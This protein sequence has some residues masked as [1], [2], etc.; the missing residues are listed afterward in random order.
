VAGCALILVSELGG[1]DWLRI[2]GIIFISFG[3]TFLGILAGLRPPM[4]RR[5]QASLRPWRLPA[6][7]V[8]TVLFCLPVLIGLIGGL[9]GLAS[10]FNQHN[11]TA[12]V[13]GGVAI[14]LLMIVA[15]VASALA[16]ARSLQRASHTAEPGFGA[17]GHNG[18]R[19]GDLT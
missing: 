10:A 7:L 12:V 6:S 19:D 2:I 13:A 3:A 14:D 5:W 11:H 17:N 8:L 18:H 1:I 4:E 16:V 15:T 9:F